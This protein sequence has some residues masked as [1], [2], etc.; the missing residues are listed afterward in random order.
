RITR[1]FAAGLLEQVN[2]HDPSQALIAS[3]PP[4][5]L[6]WRPLARAQYIEMQSLLTGYLL[7]AQGDRMLMGN[8]VEGRF[9]FL[10]HRLI[11]QAAAVPER[12]KLRGLT[13]KWI[14]RR[15]AARW[16]PPGIVAR[17]KYP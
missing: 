3:L 5:V 9:P 8:S 16:V 12:L 7:S 10:D 14:L 15:Y 1:F 17:R 13:E 2:G 11:E 4:R 6:S